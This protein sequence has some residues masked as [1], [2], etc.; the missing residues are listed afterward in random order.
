ME[1][2]QAADVVIAV[3]QSSGADNPT[4]LRLSRGI[5]TQSRA[6]LAAIYRGE[7]TNEL[8]V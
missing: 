1:F 2:I 8:A 7:T 4:V 6:D 3:V 5:R